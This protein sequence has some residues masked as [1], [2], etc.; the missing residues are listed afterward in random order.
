VTNPTARDPNAG[1]RGLRVVSVNVGLP[2]D[3]RWKDRTVETGIFKEPV[4][5]RVTVRR[6]NLEGDRQ[7]DLSVHGGPD[8]AVYAYPAE[9]YGYWQAEL[10]RELPWG[11]FGENLTV[12]GLPLEDEIAIGDRL[13]VGSA[14]FV[15][16]QPRVPCYKLGIRFGDD[17]MVKRFVQ[18][19]RSGYYLRVVVEGEVA[20][21]DEIEV[22]ERHD[23]RLAVSEI[24]RLFMHDRD[25][26]EGIRRALEVDALPADW[27]A[28]FDKRLA[29]AQRVTGRSRDADAPAWAGFRPFRVRDKV[30]EADRVASF[31]LEPSDGGALPPHRPGQFITLRV[32]I[33]GAARPVIRSYSI[34]DRPTRDTYRITVKDVDGLVSGH[35]HRHIAV[36]HE[37]ELKAPAG[38]FTL[39]R[40]A[41]ERPVVLVAGGIGIT[42]LLAMLNG[43]V[44]A[45]STRP[46]RLFYG[47]RNEQE[48]VFRDWLDGVAAAHASVLIERRYSEVG[49]R[50]TVDLLRQR[51]PSNDCDFYVCGPPAMM[52]AITEGLER[53]DV[54]PP[55]IHF[56][57]FGPAT[58]KRSAAGGATQPA[59]GF[60]VDFARSN[61]ADVWTDCDSPLLELAEEN[62]VEIESGC[63]AGSCGTCT[64]VLLSG[65]ID[66]LHRPGAPLAEGEILP[67]IAI[68]TS[69]VVL[70]A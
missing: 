44:A 6:L 51:L 10:G 7:A 36:G 68:P 2:R 55:Q 39:E 38:V 21:G 35:L 60:E 14:E 70:D 25:D 47:L 59:C 63:R 43:L 40:D 53:W 46:V 33:P 41:S 48:Q 52:S 19:G 9:H 45:R 49:D 67:C 64:T 12:E 57:A 3:V 11:M 29:E 34:S 18:A 31:Y 26:L 27:R 1:P 5:G 28:F 20:R 17:R 54:P 37:L 13:R 58:V 50:V 61:I 62:D 66:Y 8:K 30:A 65:S 56:E 15:V 22:T 4:E 32:P 69:D 42:P 24:T 23:A 16:S